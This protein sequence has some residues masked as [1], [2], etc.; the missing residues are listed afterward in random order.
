MAI[1]YSTG[2]TLYPGATLD[3]FE[4]NLAHDSYFHAVVWDGE[5]VTTVEYGSTAYANEWGRVEIDATPDV[6]AA[7]LAWFGPRWLATRIAEA[8]KIR[9][10][11]HVG[12]RVR[13]TTTRG[14]NVGVIGTARRIVPN[15]YSRDGSAVRV[16]V[17][18]DGTG[19]LRWMDGERLEV[20]DRQPLDTTELEE[21]A[22][23]ANPGAWRNAV[24]R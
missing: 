21:A 13:S 18:L 12:K 22:Q 17:E 9:A 24:A 1:S 5:K 10:E 11:I 3:R 8:E 15:T 14:K 19:E 7:A 6:I 20:V 23:F 16:Q 4:E 2:E